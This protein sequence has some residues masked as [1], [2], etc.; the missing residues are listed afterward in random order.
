MKLGSR[1]F[2]GVVE[3][4]AHF[5]P[6]LGWMRGHL[7]VTFTPAKGGRLKCHQHRVRCRDGRPHHNGTDSLTQHRLDFSDTG[8]LKPVGSDFLSFDLEV[9]AQTNYVV[10]GSWCSRL[11]AQKASLWESEKLLTY[12][13]PWTGWCGLLCS[14]HQ[15]RVS[16]RLSSAVSI[17][18]KYLL[19]VSL[20]VKVLCS[21]TT[22]G[23]SFSQF[24]I[25]F[26]SPPFGFSALMPSS[27]IKTL[28]W[29]RAVHF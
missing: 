8:L 12:K 19:N 11:A 25:S 28:S 14:A 3:K 24:P 9:L 2:V 13:H 4:E 5:F 18:R 6:P 23:L 15:L 10:G 21:E 20:H 7:V 26:I 16:A 27:N 1:C 17:T 29:R 22:L